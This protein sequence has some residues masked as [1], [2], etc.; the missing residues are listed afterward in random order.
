MKK[1]LLDSRSHKKD[2]DESLNTATK[3]IDP[4]EIVDLFDTVEDDQ[5]IMQTLF[6]Q[7]IAN[8]FV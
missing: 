8:S 7:N 3:D 1:I 2:K 6:I 4:K 5:K